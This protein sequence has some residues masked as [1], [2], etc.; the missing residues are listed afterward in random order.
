MANKIDKINVGGADYEINL[1]TTATP[2]IAS[3][4]I[5][6]NLTVN[7]TS[8]LNG[9]VTATGD[10]TAESNIISARLI[11]AGDYV[12]GPEGYFTNAF[13]DTLGTNT[14]TSIQAGASIHPSTTNKYNLG[15]S[16][17]YW[18]QVFTRALYFDGHY[19]AGTY[20]G[21][22]GGTLT[23]NTTSDLSGQNPSTL[24]TISTLTTN[25]RTVTSY[26]N[27]FVLGVPEQEGQEGQIPTTQYFVIAFGYANIN[28]GASNTTVKVALPTT[29]N[30]FTIVATQ[31]DTGGNNQPQYYNAIKV[32]TV[33]PTN[34]ISTFSLYVYP[35]E[36]LQINYIALGYK[37]L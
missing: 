19:G 21:L 15:N 37:N 11:S 17:Q 25:G 10:I 13:I 36:S 3:L 32:D 20:Q 8:N 26:G 23:T 18:Q 34:S 28:S 2:S 1:P 27:V 7:G 4:N 35:S 33:R 24:R 16:S 12:E 30:C 5:S 14:T 6:G 29:M 22:A 31:N 9:D